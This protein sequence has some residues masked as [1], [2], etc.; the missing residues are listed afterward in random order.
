LP[1]LTYSCESWKSTKVI[2]EKL[3]AL[4]NKCLREI[5][6]THWKEFKS[7]KTLREETKQELVSTFIK[8]CHWKHLR[9]VL[10]MDKE[11]LP[12]QVFNWTPVVTRRHGRP[13]ETLCRTII[14]ESANI[15]V[16]THHLQKLA[17]D[18]RCW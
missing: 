1:V 8:R 13:R 7:N 17:K 3:K 2:E 4:E 11:R 6:N 18:R 5:T 14:R 15:N 16:N 12:R 9:Q 10:R